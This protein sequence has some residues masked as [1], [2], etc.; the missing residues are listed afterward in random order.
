MGKRSARE[1][2]RKAEEVEGL[3]VIPLLASQLCVL[4]LGD[5]LPCAERR[6]RRYAGNANG[7][8]EWT[9]SEPGAGWLSLPSVVNP[10]G[11]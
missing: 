2:R 10:A 5:G 7:M 8:L 3:D 4:H 11:P 1:G 6:G 9:A